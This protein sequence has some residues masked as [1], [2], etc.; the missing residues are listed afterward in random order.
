MQ[1]CTCRNPFVSACAA[2][3]TLV[4]VRYQ[5]APIK[6]TTAQLGLLNFVRFVRILPPEMTKP[7]GRPKPIDQVDRLGLGQSVAYKRTHTD[8]AIE[9][10]I[11]SILVNVVG[12]VRTNERT[13][14]T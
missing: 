12:L 1:T 11:L 9:I 3:A 6:I 5:R 8:T 2:K 7:S 14:K 13:N 10:G 4:A